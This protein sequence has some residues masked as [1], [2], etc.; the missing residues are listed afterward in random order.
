M[1]KELFLQR[2]KELLSGIP[3]AE[4]EEALTYYRD[5]FEDAGIEN[6]GRVLE[7][8]GS[9]EKVAENILKD[10]GHPYTGEGRTNTGTYT[11]A[12][13]GNTSGDGTFYA[14][15][16]EQKEKKHHSAAWII[17]AIATCWLW[18]PLLIALFAVL[19]G[20]SIALF[21]TFLS[22]G[23]AALALIIAAFAL[24]GFGIVKMVIQ[25]AGGMLLLG[26]G[27]LLTGLAIFGVILTGAIFR[28][29]PA[30]F[31]GFA[32]IWS[33]IFRRRGTEA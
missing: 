30:S 11:Y 9:P 1:N 16:T 8:L 33:K 4:A 31:R 19:F 12:Q 32:G 23:I 15:S 27:L 18:G 20:V 7:E 21:A 22:L 24:I 25:P 26:A 28:L 3:Q 14:G 29:V 13:N 10:L 2:L 17:T 6:E 5:Y